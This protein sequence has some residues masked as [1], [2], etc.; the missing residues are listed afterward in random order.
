MCI[1][2]R[3]EYFVGLV[4]VAEA[5]GK[6][7]HQPLRD[8]AHAEA[9]HLSLIHIWVANCAPARVWMWVEAQRPNAALPP[10]L[11]IRATRMPSITRK[12]VSYTHLD[13]YKRQGLC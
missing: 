13:V 6:G 2:D 5:L 3:D 10:A 1:R 9:L 4:V 8:A 11:F 7:V 12:T